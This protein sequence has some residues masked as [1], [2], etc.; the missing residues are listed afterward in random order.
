MFELP[1]RSAKRKRERVIYLN[2]QR[3]RNAVAA[4]FFRKHIYN[5]KI[6]ID[7]QLLYSKIALDACTRKGRARTVERRFVRVRLPS[8][9][10]MAFFYCSPD[11]VLPQLEVQ[12]SH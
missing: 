1:R 11:D 6:A 12:P 3:G 10:L 5:T 4:S 8:S 2:K 9:V 7:F